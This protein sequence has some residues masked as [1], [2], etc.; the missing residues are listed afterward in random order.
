MKKLKYFAIYIYIYHLIYLVFVSRISQTHTSYIN[1]VPFHKE[2]FIL[3][4]R[5]R[6]D[7]W[8][9]HSLVYEIVGNLFLLFPLP[10]SIMV[11]LN[12]NDKYLI[13][14]FCFF[15]SL[16]IESIQYLFGLGIADI[17]DIILNNIGVFIAVLL[18]HDTKQYNKIKLCF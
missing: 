1:L 15:I 10:I 17:D 2:I 6:Y 16:L 14:K 18:I 4:I 9:I 5:H 7:F 3:F 8:V 13:F 11:L 12:I